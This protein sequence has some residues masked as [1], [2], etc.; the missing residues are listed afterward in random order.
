MSELAGVVAAGGWLTTSVV[1]QTKRGPVTVTAYDKGMVV[2]RGDDQ[3]EAENVGPTLSAAML[4]GARRSATAT[5]QI[6]TVEVQAPKAALG[7]KKLED[8]ARAAWCEAFGI[9]VASEQDLAVKVGAAKAESRS[10]REELLAE[11]RSGSAGVERWNRLTLLQRQ[12]GGPFSSADLCGADL[13]GARLDGLDFQGAKFD[14]ADLRNAVLSEYRYHPSNFKEASFR[15][16]RLDGARLEEGKYAAADFSTASLAGAVLRQGGFR[17]AV[18]VGADLR[19]ANLQSADLRGADLSSAKLGG[20]YIDA[21]K[22]DEHTRFPKGFKLPAG[23]KWAGTGLT[24][25]K[26][27]V[28]PAA[29]DFAAF[30]QRLN[31]NVE[32]ARLAKGLAM[33]KAD[34]FRLFA[35]VELEQ[36]VGV[37][38]SQTDRELV[39]SCRLACDGNFACCTQNL[40]LCGGLCG[41]LCKHLLV[42]IVGLAKTEQVPL[43]EVDRWVTASRK[44]KPRLD[45]EVMAATFLR[46]QGAEAG[47]V[48]W[49]PTETIPEDYAAL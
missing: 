15:N 6:D 36:L 43:E 30:M 35:Q 32:G 2:R 19:K 40:K 13:R 49:R 17:K 7:G 24:P 16:A 29:L 9:G 37:V 18:F 12:N 45:A 31:Q 33:L 28:P 20:A 27:A 34:R 26:G 8:L 38:R 3:Y 46:Y 44:Q 39:Y 47:E 11:L 41:A 22:Y 21:T 14:D 23:L 42:L 48:D 25:S 10:R 4:E 1:V 5:V